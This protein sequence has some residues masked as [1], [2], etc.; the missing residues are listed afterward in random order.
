MTI[1]RMKPSY[2]TSRESRSLIECNH[3]CY[4]RVKREAEAKAEAEAEAEAA[5]RPPSDLM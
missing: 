1:E 2:P 3:S 5:A 4:G